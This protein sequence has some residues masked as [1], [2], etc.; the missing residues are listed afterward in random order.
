MPQSNESTPAA[1]RWWAQIGTVTQIA[2]FMIIIATSW[3]MLKELATLLRPLAMAVLLCYVLL[4]V[5]SR[6]RQDRSNFTAIMLMTGGALAIFAALGVIVY[7]SIVE[8]NNAMPRLSQRATEMMAEAHDWSNQKL[9]SWANQGIDDA[10]VAQPSGTQQLQDW[11]KAV[12]KY[13]ADMLLEALVVALY[14]MFIVLEARGLRRQVKEGFGSERAKRILATLETINDSVANYLK[15]KVRASLILAVPVTLILLLFGVKFALIW[16]LLTFFCNFIPYVGTVVACTSPVVFSFLDLPFGYQPF[17]VA[18]LLIGCHAA[19]S[20]LVEPMMIGNAVGLSPL[21]ILMSLTFWGL[22][23]GIV[24]MFLAV[25][26][27][28][29]LKIMLLNIEQTWGIAKLLGEE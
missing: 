5:H 19:S 25:P 11:G 7:G 10:M 28:V 6:L 29:T 15:T 2:V 23:W 27:T 4:P 26:L 16:G 21:I 24:G 1:S 12:L 20:S 22:C 14:V 17:A 9:P 3:Y 8:M 13:A 18:V